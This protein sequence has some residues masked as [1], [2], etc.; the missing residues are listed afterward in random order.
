MLPFIAWSVYLRSGHVFMSGVLVGHFESSRGHGH[1]P[2]EPEDPRVPGCGNRKAVLLKA[3]HRGLYTCDQLCTNALSLANTWGTYPAVG[4]PPQTS[5][6]TAWKGTGCAGGQMKKGTSCQEHMHN[7]C[8]VV[9]KGL[10]AE[11]GKAR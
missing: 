11:H 7:V 5:R 4:V 6:G 10:L 8:G 2:R 3:P 9:W 1:D